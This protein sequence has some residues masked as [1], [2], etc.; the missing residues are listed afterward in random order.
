MNKI[1]RCFL[2]F[3]C[4]IYINV[5]PLIAQI[6]NADAL[7]KQF[8]IIGESSIYWVP[9]LLQSSNGGL[10]EMAQYHGFALNW[11]PRGLLSNR[12]NQINGID[13][14]T[15]LNGWDPSFSYAGL[16]R[17]F[18]TINLNPP[19]GMNAFGISGPSGNSF[20]S[21]NAAL[22][23]K[24]KSISTSVSNATTMQELRLQWHSGLFKKTYFINVGAVLQKTPLGYLANGIK[25]RQGFLLSI[26]KL[27]SEKNNWDFLFGGVL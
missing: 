14:R 7:P 4:C 8:D 22:F 20:M 9:N 6:E 25:D 21:S 11:I 15:N 27:I 24:T 10:Q 13:W 17:G 16:Y 23:T 26:E 5:N 18:K 1:A 19:Y 3:S 2:L 12:G